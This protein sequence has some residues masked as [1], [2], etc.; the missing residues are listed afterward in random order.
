MNKNGG[1]LAHLGNSQEP[2]LGIGVMGRKL[3]LK[4]PHKQIRI[5]EGTLTI[6][7]E[8]SVLIT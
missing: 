7:R 1:H 5:E 8:G 6:L 4:G 3:G 2:Y